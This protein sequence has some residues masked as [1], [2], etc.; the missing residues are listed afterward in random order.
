MRQKESKP[1]NQLETGEARWRGLE[2]RRQR[3]WRKGR[4]MREM[5][6]I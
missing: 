2:T 6:H 4:E 5:N 1:N 3:K